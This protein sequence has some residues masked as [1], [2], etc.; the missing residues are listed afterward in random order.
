MHA[1]LHMQASSGHEAVHRTIL[2]LSLDS[3]SEDPDRSRWHLL[4]I[5]QYA[6]LLQLLCQNHT[7][8]YQYPAFMTG[9]TIAVS[10]MIPDV[11]KR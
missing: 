2:S 11:Q 6:C 4:S 1:Q 5:L 9:F 10:A 8:D 3:R 7:F